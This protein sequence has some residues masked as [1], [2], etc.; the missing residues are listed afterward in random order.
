MTGKNT[1]HP[2]CIEA[3]I[4]D[5]ANDLIV[6]LDPHGKVLVWNRAAESITGYPRNEVVGRSD[7]WRRLYPDADYRRMITKRITDIITS[8]RYFK[9]LETKIVTK[10]G[11]QRILSWNTRQVVSGGK[12]WEIAI[13]RDITEIAKAK[14][15]IKRNAEF[16]E[17]IIINAKLWMT[18][19][20]KKS[21]VV[22]WNKAAEEITGYSSDEVVGHGNVWKWV[23]PDDLYRKE[24]TKKIIDIIKN[25]KYLENFETDIRTK[26]GET[27]RISW[28]TRELTGDDGERLGYIVVGNDITEQR[29]TEAFQKSIID[30]AAVLI[31]VLDPEGRILQWNEAA[32]EITGYPRSET[33]GNYGIWKRIY[34]DK[35]YRKTITRQIQ[36][37]ISARRHFANFETSITTK[38]GDKKIISW[39]TRQ[40]A[41]G[42]GQHAIAIGVDITEQRKAEEALVAYMTEM[43]MRMKQPVEIIR[44]NLHDVAELIREG[45][46]TPEETALLLDGQVRNA[47]QIETN[48]QE[49]QKAIV[50]KNRAIPEAYRKFLEGD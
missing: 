16:Q 12:T 41:F 15:E 44:D 18:F 20:D 39:N 22:I 9:N 33:I 49:F 35:E 24:V 43:T 23:Y 27:R 5:S 26:T 29:K 2:E 32:E 46:I 10:T 40:I 11:E 1:K 38:T 14:R 13:G 21:N 28:N 47:T 19:L 45:K 3:D 7:V 36:E 31:A 37:V 48:V 8:R 42:G 34:P 25:K 4:I 30:N 6:V 50:E 17:S